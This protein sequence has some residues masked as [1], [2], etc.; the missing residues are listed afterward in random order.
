MNLSPMDRRITPQPTIA[1]PRSQGG[2]VRRQP[3]R[4]QGKVSHLV[5][6]R[7]FGFLRMPGYDGDLF[8]HFTSLPDNYQPR[9]GDAVSFELGR[10]RSDRVTA[11]N[12]QVVGQFGASTHERTR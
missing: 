7:W 8:F 9:R 5:S 4:L 2:V 12:I 6:G 10:D 3:V 1:A 11:V